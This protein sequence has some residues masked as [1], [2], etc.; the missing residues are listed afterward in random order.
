MQEEPKAQKLVL[1]LEQ[2]NFGDTYSLRVKNGSSERYRRW[3]YSANRIQSEQRDAYQLFKTTIHPQSFK[4]GNI[5]DIRFENRSLLQSKPVYSKEDAMEILYQIA[6][7]HAKILQEIYNKRDF[8]IEIQDRV[9]DAR[10]SP[11]KDI[12]TPPG[13]SLEEISAQLAYQS[14]PSLELSTHF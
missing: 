10:E 14:S 13:I 1:I 11:V 4:N 9:R 3:R 6:L 5:K 12:P 7:R 2:I 8:E